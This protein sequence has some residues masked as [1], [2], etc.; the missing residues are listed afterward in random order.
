MKLTLSHADLTGSEADLLVVPVLGAE[1]SKLET[2]KQLDA[3]LGGE[4][5]RIAKQEDFTGKKGQALT[6]HTFGKIA[7]KKLRLAAL[8]G[9][10][11]TVDECRSVAVTTARVAKDIKTLALLVPS[12]EPEQLRAF[13]EGL[14]LG[15]YK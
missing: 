2:V 8:S 1:F 9:K 7:A 13:A 6:L 11:I 3:A 10:E 5:L 4:L 12:S 14:L 15:D